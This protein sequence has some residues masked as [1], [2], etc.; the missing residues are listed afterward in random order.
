MKRII[1]IFLGFLG[2]LIALPS[3]SAA[4]RNAAEKDFRFAEGLQNRGLY[5]MAITEYLAFQ[6]NYPKHEACEFALY[7]I[8]LI[9]KDTGEEE[10]GI[11]AWEMLQEKYPNSQSAAKTFYQI[12]EMYL[13]RG[14]ELL[15]EFEKNKDASTKVQALAYFE[16]SATAYDD[17]L[18]KGGEKDTRLV[19]TALFNL[20]TS[21]ERLQAYSKA[22]KTY[23]KLVK[24]YNDWEAQF[25]IGDVS[26]QYAKA[27]VDPMSKEI[28]FKEA[29]EGFRKTLF[30]GETEV[31]D[32][33][34]IGYAN[35][36]IEQGKYKEARESLI[37]EI[38][39]EDLSKGKFE[40]IYASFK[41][42]KKVDAIY[43]KYL[44]PRAYWMIAQC[45]EK[46]GSIANAKNWYNLIITSADRNP[47][48]KE[49]AGFRGAAQKKLRDIFEKENKA[50]AI[51]TPEVAKATL[52]IAKNYSETGENSKA[53]DELVKI[54]RGF[55][56]LRNADFY[57]DYLYLMTYACYSEKRYLEAGIFGEYLGKRL[58]PAELVVSPEGTVSRAGQA[59]YYAG[60]SY[61]EYGDELG[62]DKSKSYFQMLAVGI[63][64]KMAKLAPTHPRASEAQLN[65]AGS[66]LEAKNYEHAAL[67]YEGFLAKKTDANEHGYSEALFNLAYCYLNSKQYEKAEKEYSK[68]ATLY[69]KK[70]PE[71]ITALNLLGGC[72][73][74]AKRY[75]D[76]INALMKLKPED[77]KWV[78]DDKLN[79][80]YKTVFE[81]SHYQ[82]G[83]CYYQLK[84]FSKAIEKYAYFIGAF[85]SNKKVP[86][87]TFLLA[88]LYFD[89]KD[90][91]NVVKV[92]GDFIAKHSDAPEAYKGYILLS[93]SYLQTKNLDK[94]LETETAM[95]KVYGKEQLP[96]D[97]YGR[98]AKVMKDAGNLEG[99]KM[100]Y[101]ELISDYKDE[102][103]VLQSA[104][105]FSAE[106]AFETM[107]KLEK[108][109]ETLTDEQA[110]AK[111]LQE[112]KDYL[113]IAR[114]HYK[115][116]LDVATANL[117]KKSGDPNKVPGRWFELQFRIGDIHERL[118]EY[119]EAEKT[120]NKVAA[121]SRDNG[122]VVE[123]QYKIGHMWLR[124]GDPKK[125][126]G[127]FL[128]LILMQDNK[129]EEIRKWIAISTYEA[130]ICHIR[131]N[132]PVKAKTMLS[133][134]LKEYVEPEY[135][136]LRDDAEKQLKQ[137]SPN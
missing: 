7:N 38:N 16:K 15:T 45:Y 87:T 82:I 90:H 100:A 34:K 107:Q 109:F 81:Y 94:A 69:D 89:K 66:Y 54:R 112:Q 113:S 4:P 79:G 2:F 106:F 46:E 43:L 86:E 10:K 25:K 20:A 59:L 83:F 124:A 80:E 125:A 127:T 85:P 6:K 121:Q 28:H 88:Q 22:V 58:N 133:D 39:M 98:M 70:N 135:K 108:D 31:Y 37:K 130:G 23:E 17:Y 118:G 55:A 26:L 47:T 132:E 62:T 111:N 119:D 27:T 77:F 50:N 44:A 115:E 48:I 19:I 56:G 13:D 105:W 63:Y 114:N 120:Y 126:L 136:N 29:L 49:F 1:Q 123:A 110:K 84:D 67:N 78:G 95:F 14:N 71:V 51:N 93:E 41:D 61:W 24:D 3:F 12:A 91:D 36:L 57:N 122:L 18:K 52:E 30:F 53:I 64:E 5:R 116:Y 65:A 103:D 117:R 21:Y 92:L 76:A 42:S 101:Q 129:N 72:L 60:T 32:D 35:A 104:L 8:G 9:Y 96:R 131:N 68:Y 99:A 73:I 134:F 74:R 128:R 11:K 33:A 137:M 75:P 102:P 40:K 97:A